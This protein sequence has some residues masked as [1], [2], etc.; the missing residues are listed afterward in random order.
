[1]KNR[2]AGIVGS[3]RLCEALASQELVRR[4]D[5]FASYLAANGNLLE[6]RARA[7]IVHQDD[8]DT[9]VY[10]I[11]DG[12]VEVERD[13]VFITS[14]RS[15]QSI[16]ERPPFSPTFTRATTV[17]ARRRTLVFRINEEVFQSGMSGWKH[18]VSR[19]TES[20][21]RQVVDADIAANHPNYGLSDKKPIRHPM[22]FVWRAADLGPKDVYG[23]PSLWV[24]E[25][26][27]GELIV[28]GQG[29]MNTNEALDWIAGRLYRRAVARRAPP[30]EPGAPID[31]DSEA[32][33]NVFVD[34]SL[35]DE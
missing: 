8:A 13:G 17:S 27:T 2:F 26:E 23:G 31:W 6:F 30:V 18:V 11:I 19:I 25:R 14:R 24:V 20:E 22:F 9:D 7:R 5:E 29:S 1:M 12:E 3:R 34:P 35:F 4:D 32:E 33:P 21:A 15:G 28:T 16:D 10:L